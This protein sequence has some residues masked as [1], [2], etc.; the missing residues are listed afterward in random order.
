MGPVRRRGRMG[1]LSPLD[2]VPVQALKHRAIKHHV[3]VNSSF[4]KQY[5]LPHQGWIQQPV[6]APAKE[7]KQKNAFFFRFFP[8]RAPKMGP[9][10][11]KRGEMDFC[12]TDPDLAD[13][14]GRTDLDFE[15]FWIIRFFWV[16]NFWTT[17]L[18]GP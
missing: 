4:M 10:G 12:P 9:D 18:P 5:L 6:V 7:N 15:H 2:A 3:L 11:P 17:R 13:I 14:L 1:P 16:P 8:A